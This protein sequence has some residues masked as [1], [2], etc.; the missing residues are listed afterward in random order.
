M[1]ALRE[2]LQTLKNKV[3]KFL[4]EIKAKN[5]YNSQQVVALNKEISAE[6]EKFAK[7][8]VDS[9]KN[10][11]KILKKNS[12]YKES[13][14]TKISNDDKIIVN[15]KEE[16]KRLETDIKK[17]EAEIRDLEQSTISMTETFKQTVK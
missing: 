8:I 9:W 16:K 1:K 14:K 4:K 12:E 5:M 13:L 10:Y 15:L 3:V 11:Q 6:K 17:R 7:E 2:E